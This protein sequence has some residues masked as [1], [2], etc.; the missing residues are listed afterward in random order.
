MPPVEVNVLF[1]QICT[2]KKLD[3]FHGK[4]NKS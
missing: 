4:V 3:N 1:Q 2:Q